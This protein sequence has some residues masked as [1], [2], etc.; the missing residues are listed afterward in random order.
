MVTES[1]NVEKVTQEITLGVDGIKAEIAQ[2]NAAVNHANEL[3][4]K[5]PEIIAVLQEE[6]S[7]F[8]V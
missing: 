7:W 2:L 6:L 1:S 8:K 5:I 3:S 4:K